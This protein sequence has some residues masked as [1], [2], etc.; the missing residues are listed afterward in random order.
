MVQDEG[1][2]S[3]FSIEDSK[4]VRN[5]GSGF[6]TLLEKIELKDDSGIMNLM[7]RVRKDDIVESMCSGHFQK[8]ETPRSG[9]SILQLIDDMVKS[10]WG[11]FAFDY[12]YS[13]SVGNSGGILCVWDPKSF[14]KLNA[15]QELIEK[16]MLWDYL[17]LVM[18][19][20]D[21]EVV[22][23]GNF[24]EGHKKAKRFRFVFNVQGV[25]VFNMFISNASL[26]EVPLADLAELDLVIDKG[27]GDDDVAIE[28]DENSKYYHAILNKKR[29]Q[30]AI[31]G[32]LVD[33]NWI[34]SPELVKTDLECEVT[35]DE[36]KRAVWDCGIDKS[37]GPDGF[38]FGFY[39]QYWKIIESDV[40]DAVICFF[41]QGYFPKGGNSSFI[42]LIP[43]TPDANMVKDFRPISL[44]WSLYK[45]IAKILVNRLV[46]VLGNL[47]NEVQSVFVVDRE[48]LDGPFI[49]NEIFQWCRSK[50]KHS[51]VFKVDFD[52]AYDSVRWDYLDDIM[53][54][55]GFGDKWR[56][57]LLSPFLFILVIE[58]L[59]VS[60]QRVVD[61]GLFNDITLSYSLH[62]SHMFY[63]DDAIFV[64]QWN[65]S[66]INTIV[67][68]LDCFHR[69][70]G[71][72]INMSRSKLLGI[73]VDA[74]KLDQ[75]ASKIDCVTPKTPIIYLG[76]KVGRLMSR[77]QSWNKTVEG[78]VTRLSNGRKPFQV[79]TKLI[80][81]NMLSEVASK[82]RWIKAMPIKVNVH[83]WKIK[84]DCLPTRINISRKGMDIES[85]LC[86]M[87]GEAVESSRHIFLICRI[88]REILRK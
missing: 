24:N 4:T 6:M 36:I 8:V 63:A 26:E 80:D 75:A 76:S 18:E 61:V 72:R 34:E 59:H 35:K 45:I 42:A 71:L 38:M 52:K 54:K 50:K 12:V 88:A 33:G 67:H 14:K 16:K 9:G 56:G 19:N 69:A 32:I 55:F 82:S 20:W 53:R 62:L 23:M 81:D 65:E 17:S 64:G 31:R 73:Y 66:N 85:I 22:I 25:D 28:G 78:M 1:I 46:V 49:L 7:T 48:I 83:A 11:N 44:I 21:G 43:K 10:C 87:C 15:P 68:I 77:I 60:F 2:I 13:A 40:V 30:L 74:D 84:L 41:Q 79:I 47:V 51:L 57:N 29:S 70:S 86:S 5:T 27:E 39:R 37:P 3:N 58:S